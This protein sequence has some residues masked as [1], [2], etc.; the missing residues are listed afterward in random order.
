ML[1]GAVLLL[2]PAALNHYPIV[3]SDLGGLLSMGHEP[4]IGWDKP[5]VYGPFLRVADGGVTLW[6]PMLAQGLIVS[7]TLWLVQKAVAGGSAGRHLALCAVLAAGSAAPW[8]AALLMPDIFAPVSVLSLFLLGLAPPGTLSRGERAWLVALATFA[9]AAHLAHLV[10]ACACLAVVLLLRWRRAALAGAPLLLALA[11][12]A[13]A[14]LAGNGVAGVSPYGSIFALARLQADGPAARYL[15]DVCPAAGY[16]LC[17]W[18]SR[19]P[20]DSDAFLWRPDGP[21]WG[22]DYGPTLMVGEARQVVAAS[23]RAYPWMAARAAA[24]NTLAQARLAAVGDT[25]GPD[26]LDVTVLPRLERF[27]PAAEAARFGAGLQARGLLLA[28]AAP[29]LWPQG[30][31]LAAGLLGTLAAIPLAWR[32][33]P[34]LAGLALMVLAG[35]AANAFATG[36]LSHPHDR[37]GARIAWL[38]LLPPLLALMRP[39]QR[40][41]SADP[42]N[43][44]AATNI[45]GMQR[46]TLIAGVLATVVVGMTGLSFAAVPLYRAFCA[47]T[48]YGGT[49][50]IG[51]GAAPGGSTGTITVAFNADVNPNLPWRFT[52]EAR[53]VTLALGDQ[54]LAFFDAKNLGAA[55]ITGVALYNVTPETVGRYFHKTQCFCFD[56][57]TLQ[58]GEAMQFPVT[59]WVDPAIARDP[60]TRDVHTITLSYTFFRSLDDAAR[61][62]AL[63]KAGPHSANPAQGRV[64]SGG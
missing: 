59:F 58:P 36:A 50:Q 40:V 29:F 48:G 45:R 46:N 12:L 56:S 55:P 24:A 35:L 11:W 15:Q 33:W 63:A 3:F 53:Q 41:R 20:E 16:R 6:L 21:V 4:E 44:V 42:R 61:N 25:L 23:L 57:Q 2:W 34:A 38:V 31:L 13:S 9:I 39:L 62:G 10:V 28:A 54:Q 30:G 8:F 51:P 14:N 49:P 27:F 52:P 32:R 18:A 37:Y 26:Y 64:L 47:A 7:H 22:N 1:A 60:E 5:W 43:P 19:L 17:A